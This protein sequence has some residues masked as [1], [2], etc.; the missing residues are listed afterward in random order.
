MVYFHN[1]TLFLMREE[2]NF[3]CIMTACEILERLEG[4][5]LHHVDRDFDGGD[6]S[7]SCSAI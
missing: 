6:V 7:S 2:G 4:N 3:S 5:F 1:I